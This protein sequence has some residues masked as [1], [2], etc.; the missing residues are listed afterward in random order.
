MSWW[1]WIWTWQPRR[2]FHLN[3]QAPS[4]LSWTFSRYVKLRV[5]H[6]PGMFSPPPQ[7]SDPDMHHGT[8]V[9]HVPWCMPGSLTSGFL[10]SQWRGIRSR[11]S[12]RKRNLQ[13]AYLARGPLWWISVFTGAQDELKAM[14]CK[15]AW[16][17]KTNR[18]RVGDLTMTAVRL[19]L[20]LCGY[21]TVSILVFVG[22]LNI[23]EL[24]CDD[25]ELKDNDLGSRFFRYNERQTETRTGKCLI[26]V[27][28]FALDKPGLPT[29]TMTQLIAT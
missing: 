11:Y 26:I 4:S 17:K 14:R 22:V 16:W 13:F 8:C 21:K 5:A 10:W 1:W 7:V 9:T 18:G 24:R 27:N 6:A 2:G 15:L 12:R 19:S 29:Q 23:V 20:K 25:I 3:R 28:G